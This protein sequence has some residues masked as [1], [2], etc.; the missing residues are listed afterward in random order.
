MQSYC[1]TF[2]CCR[3]KKYRSTNLPIPAAAM[4]SIIYVYWYFIVIVLSLPLSLFVCRADIIH[5]IAL[6]LWAKNCVVFVIVVI[7]CEL[8]LSRYK[9]VFF[10]FDFLFLLYF[11]FFS[12][13]FSSAQQMS[14]VRIEA[15]ERRTNE[16]TSKPNEIMDWA[17]T[18]E[19]V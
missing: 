2:Q 1:S 5:G 12:S 7:M 11:C 18:I 8:L 16:W 9:E 14:S 10:F 4:C 6:S 13:Q 3:G 15:S 17:P 19:P